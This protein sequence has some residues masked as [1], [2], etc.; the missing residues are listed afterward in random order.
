MLSPVTLA[1]V[2]LIM[3]NKGWGWGTDGGRVQTTTRNNDASF[4][5]EH[6]QTHTLVWQTHSSY[7]EINLVSLQYK[8]L[9]GFYL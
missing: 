2:I 7:R 1:T 5:Q 9:F 6:G 8:R 4:W 3:C